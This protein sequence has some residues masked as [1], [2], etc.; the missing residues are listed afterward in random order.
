[1]KKIF[2]ALSVIVL[3]SCN[4]EAKKESP[5]V[6]DKPATGMAAPAEDKYTAAMVANKKDPICEM[7]VT[8]GISDTA[9][10]DGKAYGFCSP[11]CKA[12]FLKDAQ[13]YIKKMQ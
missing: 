13:A 12:E 3:A 2:I 7:P 9:H 11:D 4:N 5:A 1:M 8:A 6:T 10:V